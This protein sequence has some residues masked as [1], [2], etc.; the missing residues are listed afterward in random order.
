MVIS[1]REV[2]H[3]PHKTPHVNLSPSIHEPTLI[4]PRSLMF[5]CWGELDGAPWGETLEGKR[6]HRPGVETPASST[7]G[8][9]APQLWPLG[10][11]SSVSHTHKTPV[12]GSYSSDLSPAFMYFSPLYPMHTTFTYAAVTCDLSTFLVLFL[13]Y[14]MWYTLWYNVMYSF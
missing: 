4:L 9:H 13:A 8:G 11:F 3:S 6:K 14:K 12:S 2:G 1:G 10:F 7:R 5:P